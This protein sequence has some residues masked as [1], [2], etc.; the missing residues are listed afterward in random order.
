MAP[1]LMLMRHGLLLGLLT[2]KDQAGYLMPIYGPCPVRGAQLLIISFLSVTPFS[3]LPPPAAPAEKPPSA[4][5]SPM[6]LSL[7]L[8]KVLT[9][10]GT[11]RA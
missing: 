5:P 11:V 9:N 4:R 10:R 7:Q 8:T 3:S 6:G 1:I 2:L